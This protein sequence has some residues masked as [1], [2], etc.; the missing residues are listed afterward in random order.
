MNIS[1]GSFAGISEGEYPHSKTLGN[2]GIDNIL[3]YI[4]NEK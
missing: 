3:T 1:G 4:Q 2:Y